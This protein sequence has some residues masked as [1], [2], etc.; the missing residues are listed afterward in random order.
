[1]PRKLRE[2][3]N[4]LKNRYEWSLSQSYWK[5]QVLSKGTASNRDKREMNAEASRISCRYC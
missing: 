5:K 3:K 1:M 4:L 2:P